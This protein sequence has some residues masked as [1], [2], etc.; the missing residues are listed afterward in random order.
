[1]TGAEILT[2]FTADTS[3]VDKA[4]KNYTSGLGSLT[5]AFTL[6]SLAAQ[7]VS[8]AISV[9]SQNM[10]SAISRFDTMNNFPKVMKN[11]G[12]S[13][14][15]A[16]TSVKKLSEKL[17]GLPT[18]LDSAT[19]AVQR[20]T[21]KNSDVNKST[22]MFLAL[23]NAI[24]AGGASA[25]I[26]S[27][28]LEQISQAY[29]KGKPDMMEWRSMLQAMP[30]QLK[31]VATAMGYVDADALGED[32]RK[33]TVSM[34]EFM[35]TIMKLNTDGL[36]GLEN[37][38]TQARNATGGIATSMTNMKTAIV[39]GITGMIDTINASLQDL[40]GISG[41]LG[42]IGKGM[43]SAIKELGNVLGEVMPVL[44]DFGKQ[45]MPTIQQAFDRIMPKLKQVASK[46]IPALKKVLDKIAPIMQHFGEK[47][48]PAIEKALE[49]L[50]PVIEPLIE[51]I[52]NIMQLQMLQNSVITDL[53]TTILPPLINVLSKLLQVILPPLNKILGTLTSLLENGLS[54]AWET[55]KNVVKGFVDFFKD[56]P[57]KINEG[58]NK[59]IDFFKNLPYNI[60]VILGELVGK[61]VHFYLVDVPNFFNGVI[62]WFKKLPGK[63]WEF[64]K[65]IPGKIW[66]ALINAKD[67]ALEG[68]KQI[69]DTIVN[70][71]KELPGEMIEIGKQIVEGIKKGIEGAKDKLK[72]TVSNFANGIK[73]GLKSAF[74]IHSP[75]KL[76]KEEVG[77]NIGLG[78]VEGID[79]TKRDINKAL[80]GIGAN[81]TGG[82]GLNPSTINNMNT[83][84]GGV[85]VIVNANFETDPLGQMVR[86]IKTF[87]GGAKNDY[88]YGMGIGR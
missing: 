49:A 33:G 78:V 84:L 55:A 51:F 2:R 54:I 57:N 41:I 25:E 73:N 71:L 56:I 58:I 79:D 63:I 76:M 52:S 81:I 75:S 40:G 8:K 28:A 13:T 27:S 17:T 45:I 26:Q 10:D 50:E 65:Q 6:G 80:N 36:P 59:I 43:E 53:L 88:N 20:L 72:N 34:D 61:L 7:G 64:V 85:N 21:S 11:L 24:L 70:K 62:D 87:S 39:R 3:Q 35:N 38:E 22:D 74:G 18:A 30:A 5:K 19:R 86:D 68:A 60:G 32:L 9:I 23:N 1:M 16:D 44:T 82:V 4:T 46:I 15:D 77:I 67:K 66:T 42:S 12:I 14:E 69:F 31:Q 47:M 83:S 29:A 37:F 48:I